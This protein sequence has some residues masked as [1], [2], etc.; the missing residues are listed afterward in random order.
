MAVIAV[1][2]FAVAGILSGSGAH[3]SSPWF[4]PITLVCFG[5]AFFALGATVGSWPWTRR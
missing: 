3:I 5:L 1:V 4:S 2:L